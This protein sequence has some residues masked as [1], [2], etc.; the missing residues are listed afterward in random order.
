MEIT[1]PELETEQTVLEKLCESSVW[2]K[3]VPIVK[4][5]GKYHVYISEDI[6]N[7]SVY[8]ELAHTLK[9]KV[10]PDDEVLI[11]L[12]TPGGIIDSAN[13]LYDAII[14]C[15][16]KTTAYLTGTVASAGTLIAMAVD[17]LEVAEGTAFMAHNYSGG[18]AG[19]GHEMRAQQNFTDEQ[20]SLFFGQVY[21]KFLTKSEIKEMIDGKDLWMGKKEILKRWAR[22]TKA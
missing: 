17:N 7:P 19:K 3:E 8:N 15:P 11:H 16:G 4:Q 13:M 22:K 12:N 5:D 21:A 6:A 1:I 9:Y 18:V 20:L 14:N 10:E 2:D